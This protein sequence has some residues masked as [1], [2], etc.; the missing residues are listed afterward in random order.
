[1]ATYSPPS[2]EQ[3]VFN[4]T[5]WV[6]N[7]DY[8][9]TSG[10]S[11]ATAKGLFLSLKGNQTVTGAVKFQG[12]IQTDTIEPETTSEGVATTST[13]NVEDSAQRLVITP[14]AL[15]VVPVTDSSGTNVI[16]FT[17]IEVAG[18][19]QQVQF[20]DSGAFGGSSSF[21][22]DKTTGQVSATSINVT[23]NFYVGGEALSVPQTNPG[24][25][26]T[27]VQFND[28]G[29][30]Q[31]VSSLTYNSQSNQLTVENG[32]EYNQN[33]VIGSNSIVVNDATSSTTISAGSI[34]SGDATLAFVT[35]G[36]V[37]ATDD[38]STSASVSALYV[39][40]SEGYKVNGT[41]V[42]DN[43]S[44]GSGILD[45]SLVSVGTLGE[46]NVSGDALLGSST[47]RVRSLAQSVGIKTEP[48]YTLD[49]N[50][51]VNYSGNLL[52]N[53]VAQSTSPGG[54]NT[55]VQYNNSGSFAGSSNL[56]WD[57]SNTTLSLPLLQMSNTV[58]NKLSL[59]NGFSGNH[60]GLGIQSNRL[61][62]YTDAS[63]GSILFGYGSSSSFT[64]TARFANST[65][66]LTCPNVISS[67]KITVGTS[68]AGSYPLNVTGDINLTGS[69]RINGVAQS[70]GS[71]SS[72]SSS[73]STL[74]AY[75]FDNTSYSSTFITNSGGST[76]TVMSFNNFLKTSYNSIES[77]LSYNT[78]TGY[79]T[80][81]S[82]YTRLIRFSYNLYLLMS[83]SVNNTF[84]VSVTLKSTTGTGMGNDTNYASSSGNFVTCCS[85]ITWA[86][87]NN[88]TVALGFLFSS[89]NM[90]QVWGSVVVEDLSSLAVTSPSGSSTQIQYNDSGSFGASSSLTYN[91]TTTTL[92]VP[93]VVS[94]SAI[95]V[96]TSTAGSYSLNVTGDI[97]LTG[98]LRVNGV[99]QS[100]SSSVGSVNTTYQLP[101]TKPTSST[102]YN[103]GQVVNV[104][105]A[106]LSQTGWYF[107]QAQICF[108][109]SN[110]GSGT[111]YL[112]IQVASSSPT[113]IDYSQPVSMVSGSGLINLCTGLVQITNTSTQKIYIVATGSLDYQIY[114]YSSNTIGSLIRYIKIG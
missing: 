82:G 67:S 19:D 104:I 24:G 80:N 72:S 74:N 58:G 6:S 93:N 114:L 70:F 30:F 56:T 97:N 49:V 50:G 62:L 96:G 86:V 38:I 71:S 111:S 107:V 26:N 98:S 88:G 44:L 41:T 48:N 31:G 18:S 112:N 8:A 87:P 84:Y 55:Q 9:T 11:L 23:D 1:M 12:G 60:Y 46:L 91:K 33:V 5:N 39:D 68:T 14:Y 90:C 13:I 27:Q 22:Y 59:Y 36:G 35:C 94:S 7:A 52:K 100:L 17:A 10:L 61:Q 4:N 95:T 76:H 85:S 32:E 106:T 53:G 34:A 28:N 57:N 78:S 63:A 43:Y 65:S 83:T 21:T 69:L 103:A 15:Q 45:S 101:S 25:S 51:D 3:G 79:F 92:S 109:Y 42:I 99:A 64:E 20:N 81:I 110:N 66:T 2:K 113:T 105:N 37:S 108:L 75:Y 40:A 16:D 89:S 47:F 77:V 29:A 73:Y 102:Y 54:S